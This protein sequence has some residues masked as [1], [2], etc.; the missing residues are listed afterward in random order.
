MTPDQLKAELEKRYARYVHGANATVRVS[1]PAS[2][3][4]YVLGEVNKPGA[5][6]LH[7]G[8]VLSQALAEAGALGNSPTRARSGFCAIRKTETVVFT[9][10]YNVVRSAGM[11][12][13]TFR[14]NPETRC[15]C[16]DDENARM[17]NR[18][19]I[20]LL[21]ALLDLC[22]APATGQADNLFRFYPEL[23]ANGFYGDQ[24]SAADAQRG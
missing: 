22:A 15:K 6:K 12:Q 18:L 4:F 14:W 11:F 24:Y 1:D 16:H 17:I 10:N 21:A 23:Q 20:L 9:V 13:R 19:G 3:V 5:Y 2:H 7:S 8:E